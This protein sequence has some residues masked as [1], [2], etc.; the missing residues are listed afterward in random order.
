MKQPELKKIEVV[1][2]LI[3][4]DDR[5]LICQRRE[6]EPFPLQWEFPGGKVER[7]ESYLDALRR[8]L[9]EELDIEVG[10]A[11]EIFRH[12]HVYPGFARVDLRFFRVKEYR[13]VVRADAFQQVAW[14]ETKKLDRIDF[15]EGDLP[16]IREIAASKGAILAE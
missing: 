13:G 3:L 11:T 6:D 4:R 5:L 14:V 15:L 1:A 10:D 2:G 7:G 9:R 8:E 12:Q 16:L